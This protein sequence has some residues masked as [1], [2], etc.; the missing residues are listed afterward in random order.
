MLE[1]EECDSEYRVVRQ[2]VWVFLAGAEWWEAGSELCVFSM[3]QEMRKQRGCEGW[4][5]IKE[6]VV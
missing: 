5:R 6:A 1:S 4:R 3:G 2:K